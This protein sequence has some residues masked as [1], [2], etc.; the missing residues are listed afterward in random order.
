MGRVAD[1]LGF[2]PSRKH[3]FSFVALTC[4]AW[5]CTIAGH[6]FLLRG[7]GFP[8]SLV[9]A[10]TLVGILGL[11]VIVP[12]GPGLFGAYQIGCFT[13]LALFFP[14]SEVRGPGAALVFVSYVVALVVNAVQLGVGSLLMVRTPPARA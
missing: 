12:A 10:A 1:G 11:G 7:A 4:A 8:A 5:A 13:A 14:L 6:W 9:Q 3:L 2:L